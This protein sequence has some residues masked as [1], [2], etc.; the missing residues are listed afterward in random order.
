MLR[1]FYFWLRCFNYLIQDVI[2]EIFDLLNNCDEKATS[3]LI[4]REDSE[5]FRKLPEYLIIIII[6]KHSLLKA[7]ALVVVSGDIFE[8]TELQEEIS[9]SARF[10]KLFSHHSPICEALSEFEP[11]ELNIDKLDVALEFLKGRGNNCLV[12]DRVERTCG[13]RDPPTNF[14][15]LKSLEQDS[16]LQDMEGCTIRGAPFLPLLGDL[17]DCCV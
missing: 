9:A 16:L 7:P 1:F 17:S 13:I 12:L 3:V 5:A 15:L 4:M 11:R 8:L 2:V 10:L 6:D 14:E